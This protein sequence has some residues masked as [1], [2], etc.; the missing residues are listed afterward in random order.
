MLSSIRGGLNSFFVILLMALLVASFAIWGIGDIFTSRGQVVATIGETKISST[1]L[2]REFQNRVRSFQ[3]QFG[4]TFDTQQAISLGLHRGVLGDLIRRTTLD[5]EARVFGLIGN[6]EAVRKTIQGMEVFN[7]P[8]GVFSRFTYDNALQ[9]IG[10]TATAFE[11]SVR[12]DLA[13]IQLIEGVIAS[14]PV[15]KILSDT[16]YSF[17]K[18]KRV[19]KVLTIPASSIENIRKATD[20][21]LIEYHTN[22]SRQFMTEEYRNISFMFLDPST[23][24]DDLEITEKDILEAY[25]FKIDEYQIPEK[26]TVQLA[27]LTNEEDAKNLFDR[28]T[29][30]EDFELAA[31]ELTGFDIVDL[32]I[33]DKSFFE[34]ESEFSEEAAEKVF[35]LMDGNISEPIQTLL[36][37]QIFKVVESFEGQ[38]R[39]VIE[40]REELIQSI[41]A[42]RGQDAMYDMAGKID[43]EIA[44]GSNYESIVL[45]LELTSI[46][47]PSISQFG[48]DPKGELVAE[49]SLVLKYLPENFTKPPDSDLELIDGGEDGFYMVQVSDITEPVLKSFENVKGEV[50]GRWNADEKIRLSGVQASEALNKAKAGATLESL[51]SEYQGTL[52]TTA[53]IQRDEIRVQDNISLPVAN[54]IFS[55][56]NNNVAMERAAS[57]DG[58]ILVRVT[59]IAPGTPNIENV[60]YQALIESIKIEMES[61]FITQYQTAVQAGLG[62]DINESLISSLFT[63]DGI[64]TQG[65]PLRQ[66]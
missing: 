22:N 3:S 49:N 54:L 12:K 7:G 23:F 38:T 43:D 63:S 17:R 24:S 28:I 33:G 37:W 18:E 35:A 48:L 53:P 19:A 29:A 46:K 61:D 40:V 41:K 42:E 64:V 50:E 65:Q 16:L 1:Q 21:E 59:N 55:I 36:G 13:R 20:E 32:S 60:D 52:L 6:D 39:E 57:G 47:L 14:T 4:P 15:S 5:E 31:S 9:N 62:V 30:G 58:Y 51:I 27:V 8:T 66:F 44:A 2:I 34:I 11:E 45:N 10:Q 25:E 26:K 56:K